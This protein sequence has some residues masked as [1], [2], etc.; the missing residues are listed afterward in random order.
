MNNE[1]RTESGGGDSNPTGEP[2]PSLEKRTQDD[3]PLRLAD[4][5]THPKDPIPQ[6]Q[7]AQGSYAF[8]VGRDEENGLY[9]FKL[10]T[11]EGNR[12]SKRIIVGLRE[13]EYKDIFVLPNIIE[14]NKDLVLRRVPGISDY[15]KRHKAPS[16]QQF[17]EWKRDEY[18]M[19]RM[20][21]NEEEGVNARIYEKGKLLVPY[22][23]G[24]CSNLEERTS[25]G[26]TAGL[27]LPSLVEDSSDE[28]GTGEFV[29]REVEND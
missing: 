28:S 24:Q 23:P 14:L 16:D 10:L 20:K 29:Y 17:V 12:N 25:E 7:A 5:E 21:I 9:I 27:G 11:H 19:W 1:N 18:N 22:S 6:E 13:D 15:V 2:N 4:E 8:F 3:E 26:S